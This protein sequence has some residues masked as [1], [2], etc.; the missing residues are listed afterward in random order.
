MKTLSKLTFFAI[1]IAFNISCSK[2]EGCA[3]DNTGN[4]IIENT[5]VKY[6]LHFYKS[7]PKAS[8][9]PGDL[10]VEPSSKGTISLPA[11]NY[12][13][14][15]RLFTGGCNEDGSRCFVSWST[16]AENKELDLSS[17]EDLNLIY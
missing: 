17:C 10:I 2:E 11:G 3:T 9:T 1:L 15:I 8:N 4:I 16:L 12:T 13:T 14:H 7:S 6:R 5:N